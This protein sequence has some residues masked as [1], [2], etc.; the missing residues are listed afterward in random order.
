[1]PTAASPLFPTYHLNLM[2]MASKDAQRPRG[3]RRD[4][5]PAPRR[6]H[7]R[8]GQEEQR[9]RHATCQEQVHATLPS[10]AHA[11]LPLDRNWRTSAI[12]RYVLTMHG[13]HEAPSI[14][15]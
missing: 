15:V 1:M 3:V 12:V 8:E 6:R 4:Q 9:V 7:G 10:M 11:T 13:R 5:A 14:A 2:T